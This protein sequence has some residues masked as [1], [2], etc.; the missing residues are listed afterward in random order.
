MTL[1]TEPAT[2]VVANKV[3]GNTYTAANATKAPKVIGA[4]YTSAQGTIK[5]TET[6]AGL[7]S[8]MT[9][10]DTPYMKAARTNGLQASASRGLLNSSM[11]VGASEASAIKA[12]APFALQDS[13]SYIQQNLTNQNATNTASQFGADATNKANLSNQA[14][15]VNVSLANQSATNQASKFGADSANRADMSNQNAKLNADIGNRN[16]Q[17]SRAQFNADASNTATNLAS[18]QAQASKEL[19]VKA[20]S[21]IETN[22]MKGVSDIQNNPDVTDKKSAIASLTNMRNLSQQSISIGIGLPDVGTYEI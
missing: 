6:S 3:V 21:T 13:Q 18:Q 14:A 1:F 22:Y 12:A 8:S 5:P 17:E 19:Q 15:D 2:P 10:K 9:T 20:L 16:S 7:L 4:G 11:A